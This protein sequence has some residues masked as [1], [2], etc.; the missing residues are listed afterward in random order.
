MMI[1]RRSTLTLAT[2]LAFLAAPALAQSPLS[3]PASLKE[4]APATYKVRFDTTKGAFVVEV[5]RAWAPRGADRF[6]N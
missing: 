2:N 1:S 4:Q 6:Y 5:T 3:N